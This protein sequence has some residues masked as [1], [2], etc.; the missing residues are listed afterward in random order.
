MT[1]RPTSQPWT[2]ALLAATL[3]SGCSMFPS[4]RF[5][6]PFGRS[7]WVAIQDSA[8][9]V[10]PPSALAVTFINRKEDAVSVQIDV[11]QIDGAGDCAN[12]FRLDPEQSTRFSC[13]QQSVVVGQRYRVAIRVYNDL[14]ETNVVER[15][16]RTVRIVT[17][18][19]GGLALQ[20]E[21]AE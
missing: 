11:D 15:L 20:G 18:E 5:E 16:R 1:S 8:V 9:V 14:G 12:S 21:T 19:S 7:N 4:V 3:V 13:P 2:A 10:G 17:T 6:S